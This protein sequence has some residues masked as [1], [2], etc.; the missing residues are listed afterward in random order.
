MFSLARDAARLAYDAHDVSTI[1]RALYSFELPVRSS[2]EES[3]AAR[4]YERRE[5]RR[6]I[7]SKSRDAPLFDGPLPA[8]KDGPENV[9]CGPTPYLLRQN[10]AI[11]DAEKF[12]RTLGEAITNFRGDG[13]GYIWG[14]VV[15][16]LA[17]HDC[18]SDYQVLLDEVVDSLQEHGYVAEF[19]GTYG[20]APAIFLRKSEDHA[21]LKVGSSRLAITGISYPG[22][23][24]G[25]E[26]HLRYS[27]VPGGKE[28]AVAMLPL[29]AKM[30]HDEDSLAKLLQLFKWKFYS[31]SQLDG[32]DG[33]WGAFD[34]GDYIG[35][36]LWMGSGG[37]EDRGR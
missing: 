13:C 2:N 5:Q 36:G 3:Q 10:M 24:A 12:I 34:E 28:Q 4:A 11:S 15:H 30:M 14:D 35:D 20:R 18:R 37:V 27:D 31:Q 16:K 7:R 21:G 6:V 32:D 26:L 8:S 29:I 9:F 23:D 1:V 17:T 33:A 19:E 22:T 25:G